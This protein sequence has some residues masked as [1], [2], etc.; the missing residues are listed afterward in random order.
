MHR[1]GLFSLRLCTPDLFAGSCRIPRLFSFQY[2]RAEPEC[3]PHGAGLFFRPLKI[4]GTLE[5][6]D[7]VGIP[8]LFKK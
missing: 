4:G 2:V 5:A 6:S 7:I 1:K 8:C 3:F